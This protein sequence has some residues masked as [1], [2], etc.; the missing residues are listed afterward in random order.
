LEVDADCSVSEARPCAAPPTV[1]LE[2]CRSWLSAMPF[3][4][5][6]YPNGRQRVL[7]CESHVSRSLGLMPSYARPMV[8]AAHAAIA[9]AD[10][11][12]SASVA[13]RRS[14]LCY[15][16]CCP[17]VVA[18]GDVQGSGSAAAQRLRM[19]SDG[20]TTPMSASGCSVSAWAFLPFPC[21]HS[22]HKSPCAFDRFLWAS[23][24]PRVARFCRAWLSRSAVEA[25]A[26]ACSPAWAERR[27]V[28]SATLYCMS[29]ATCPAVRRAWLSL[30]SNGI[31]HPK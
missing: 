28:E 21:L 3:D 10:R 2:R 14:G 26:N 27:A 1:A 7:D 11:M 22:L 8:R 15:L 30:V 31:K 19:G 23:P 24:S 29:Y 25:T 4:R 5:P 16:S 18:G 17:L 12:W 13:V 9:V 6:R 20:G